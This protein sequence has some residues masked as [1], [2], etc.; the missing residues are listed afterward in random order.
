MC[1]DIWES[2]DEVDPRTGGTF[3]NGAVLLEDAN[4][5]FGGVFK[6]FEEM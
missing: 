2:F 1:V 4:T 3:E 5:V 6:G